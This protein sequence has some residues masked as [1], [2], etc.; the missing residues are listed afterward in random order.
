VCHLRDVDQEVN[1]PR[2]HSVIEADNPFISAA[3]TDPWA[4]ERDYQSQSG[5][6]ALKDFRQA[7]EALYRFLSG[8]PAAIW[9]RTARHAIFGP[10]HLA[11]MVGWI[12][13]HDRIHL[14]QL[15]LTRQ[16]VETVIAAQAAVPGGLPRRPSAAR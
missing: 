4:L 6:D 10:T 14:E 5:P 1:L 7:R 16:K 13:D 15:R 2:I 11:E 12:L 8:Q 9:R 3:D